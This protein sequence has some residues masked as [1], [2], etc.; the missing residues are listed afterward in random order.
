M[1]RGHSH[2]MQPLDV[3]LGAQPP[4]VLHR[5]GSLL[6]SLRGL[7][8]ESV[9]AGLEGAAV[10]VPD[11][12]VDALARRVAGLPSGVPEADVHFSVRMRTTP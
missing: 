3:W 6:S 8:S 9:R 12:H 7:P 5:L 10:D 4:E 2:Q 1:W 11:M